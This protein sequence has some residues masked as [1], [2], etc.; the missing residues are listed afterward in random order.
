MLIFTL[1]LNR[2]RGASAASLRANFDFLGLS[3]FSVA[4]MCLP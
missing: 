4:A 2:P 1:K 3:V